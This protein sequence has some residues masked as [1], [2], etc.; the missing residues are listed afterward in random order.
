MAKQGKPGPVRKFKRA[1][2]QEAEAKR[3]ARLNLENQLPELWKPK[4]EAEA[5]QNQELIQRSLRWNTNEV[6]GQTTTDIAKAKPNAITKM[7]AKQ[8]AL[9]VTRRNMLSPDPKVSNLAVTNL[10]RM[11]QQNQQDEKPKEST[12]QHVHLH[13]QV[14]NPYQNAPTEVIHQAIAAFVELQESVKSK[15]L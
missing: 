3:G 9:L 1:A 11:E 2:K 12:S 8:I 6:S 10:L 7:S 14:D 13:Q 4:S 5:R 15:T